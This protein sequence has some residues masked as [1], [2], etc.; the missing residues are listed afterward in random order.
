MQRPDIRSR[1]KDNTTARLFHYLKA[2][3]VASLL[4]NMQY[5]GSLDQFRNYSREGRYN[6]LLAILLTITS[7][8]DALEYCIFNLWRQ[9]TSILIMAEISQVCSFWH[10][11]PG[12]CEMAVIGHLKSFHVFL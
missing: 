8:T 5:P 2:Q 4:N 9:N 11:G 10:L 7:Q 6:S 1:K 3:S 12:F